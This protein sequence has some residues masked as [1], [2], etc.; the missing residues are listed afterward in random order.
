[1]GAALPWVRLREGRA[2]AVS[3]SLVAGTPLSSP[4]C[5]KRGVLG[6]P[7]LSGLS[8]GPPRVIRSGSQPESLSNFSPRGS[9]RKLVLPG[10]ELSLSHETRRRRQTVATTG[11]PLRPLRTSSPSFLLRAPPLP[12]G[13]LG[14]AW[15]RTGFGGGVKP[16][17]NVCIT[18]YELM[19]LSEI[20]LPVPRSPPY[21]NNFLLGALEYTARADM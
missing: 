12:P 15:N 1:M 16:S 17:S 13:S 14:L 3:P 10:M 5:V 8:P 20:S 11:K 2:R 7:A 6:H 4:W 19:T 21:K 18:N 9:P